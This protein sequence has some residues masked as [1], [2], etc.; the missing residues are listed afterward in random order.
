[1]MKKADIILMAL[2]ILVDQALKAYIRSILPVG[3]SIDLIGSFFSIT[4]VENTGAAFSILS[5]NAGIL[6]AFTGVLVLVGIYYLI[7][8]KDAHWTLHMSLSLII[9]GG[10]ANMI[11]RALKASVTDMFDF[12]FW[13]VFNIADIAV[14]VGCGLLIIYV[15]ADPDSKLKENKR[16]N[17]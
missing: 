10:I 2:V 16:N 13:P 7:K 6:L 4:H 3:G 9:S 17:G 14:C 1:M 11:D 8:H 5:G 15:L 12:H